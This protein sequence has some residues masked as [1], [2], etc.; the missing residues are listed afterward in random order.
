MQEIITHS[1]W[2][3]YTYEIHAGDRVFFTS[4][5]EDGWDFMESGNPDNA[6]AF[7]GVRFPSV[8]SVVAM[9]ET[10]VRA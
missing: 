9:V 7:I 8:S 6:F 10:I 2:D 4:R 5:R 1:D 3:F